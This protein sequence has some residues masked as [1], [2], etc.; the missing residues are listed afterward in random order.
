[1]SKIN[2][3]TNILYCRYLSLEFIISISILC[4]ISI[5]F[6]K[7]LSLHVEVRDQFLGVFPD[8]LFILPPINFSIE[9]FIIMY[10]GTLFFIIYH[11]KKPAQIITL[12]QSV[13]LLL[14]IRAISLFIFRFDAP[15]EMINLKDPIMETFIYAKNLTTQ[16]FNEHD[17]FFS[18]HTANLFLMTMIF[19]NKKLKILFIILTIMM[20]TFLVLQQAHYSIDVICAPI[21]SVMALF[22]QK[23]IKTIYSAY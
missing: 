20:G 5:A 19:K 10:G 9:I 8:P 22:L 13:S 23:K 7:F 14:I 6:S 4:I 2:N 12:I 15:E 18:G 11:L 3:L 1:V 16:Q 17:L 21:F